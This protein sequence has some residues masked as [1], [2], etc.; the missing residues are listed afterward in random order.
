M[1]RKPRT[2]NEPSAPIEP[3]PPIEPV[4]E[5]PVW[6]EPAREEPVRE[7]EKLPWLQRVEDD[8][9]PSRGGATLAGYAVGAALLI[10]VLV[11]IGYA[12]VWRQHAAS[13]TPEENLASLLPEQLPGSNYTAGNESAAAPTTAREG[14]ASGAAASSTASRPSTARTSGPDHPRAHVAAR[15]KAKAE[16]R[17]RV[18]A[19]KAVS[20]GPVHE[21][22]PE[23][24][25]H[26]KPV[27]LL[28]LA[29]KPE[30]HAAA[31]PRHAARGPTDLL[32]LG[33]YGSRAAA[34]QVWSELSRSRP[35]SNADHR[36]ERARVHGHLYYRLRAEMPARE[37][38]CAGHRRIPCVVVR[39]AP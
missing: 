5:E 1:A 7:E 26:A 21:K 17:N 27:L 37:W 39:W 20:T 12:I 36:V 28:R 25:R 34:E 3:E 30:R 10:I 33:A 18:P 19:Q 16:A 29:P 11:A 14:K 32:Q 24:R 38:Q 4:R 13:T 8:E 35:Y 2:P 31:K 23:A 6:E 22:S 15:A 9:P